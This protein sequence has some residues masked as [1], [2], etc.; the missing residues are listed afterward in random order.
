MGSNMVGA[1]LNS[2]DLPSSPAGQKMMITPQ[3]IFN[4]GNEPVPF[5]SSNS[6]LS[7]SMDLQIPTAVGADTYIVADLLF[8]GP[9]GA[10]ISYGVEIFHNGST[11]SSVASGYDAPSNSYMLN[12]PLGIDQR[13]VARVKGSAAWTGTPVDGLAELRVVDQSSSIRCGAQLFGCTVPGEG[14]VNRSNTIRAH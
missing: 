6:T 9:N 2:N 8:V 11:H 3:F 13:F 14:T 7:G 4:P 10:R 5:A 12:S 1:Y